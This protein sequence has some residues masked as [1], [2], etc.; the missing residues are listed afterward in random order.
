[1]KIGFLTKI[2]KPGVQEA[3]RFTKKYTLKLDVF[4]GDRFEPLP[5]ELH[6]HEYDILFSYISPWIVPKDIL[7]RTQKWNINFRVTKI[8]TQYLPHR[9]Y[10][11]NEN[12]FKV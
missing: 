6:N 11:S 4:S 7:D 1:M 9:R 12:Y 5:N 10:C 3:I 8:T 2:D